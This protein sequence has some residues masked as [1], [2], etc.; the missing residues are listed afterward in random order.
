LTRGT[1]LS[2]RSSNR[3][4]VGSWVLCNTPGLVGQTASYFL[5]TQH[6]PVE[7]HDCGEDR[8]TINRARKQRVWHRGDRRVRGRCSPTGKRPR[9]QELIES[10]EA[11]EGFIEHCDVPRWI[12]NTH[13]LHNGHLLRHCLP[14]DLVTPVP[15]INPANRKDEHR[16]IATAHRPKQDAKRAETAQKQAVKR[17]K[18]EVA[19]GTKVLGKRKANLDQWRRGGCGRGG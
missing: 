17:R 10:R 6:S 3:C 1:R 12:V 11:T 13:S 4:L 14:K 18:V 5:L 15:V 7:C 2:L 9:A 8:R 19:N 16:K